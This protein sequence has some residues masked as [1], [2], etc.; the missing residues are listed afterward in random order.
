MKVSPLTVIKVL[1]STITTLAAVVAAFYAVIGARDTEHF[2][3]AQQERWNTEDRPKV[4]VTMPTI[5]PMGGPGEPPP[6]FIRYIFNVTNK[7][8]EDAIDIQIKIA[9]PIWDTRLPQDYYQKTM[10]KFVN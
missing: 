9:Q 2:I 7:G 8:I 1:V 10:Q 6:D 3:S 4:V 5:T